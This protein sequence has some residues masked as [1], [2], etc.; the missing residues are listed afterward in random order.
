M[1]KKKKKSLRNDTRGY[2]TGSRTGRTSSNT[3]S[4]QKNILATK[5]EQVGK[6][7]SS[8]KVTTKAHR[9]LTALM[10]ELKQSMYSTRMCS[11]EIVKREEKGADDGNCEGEYGSAMIKLNATSVIGNISID[12]KKLVKKV[13]FLVSALL[14]LI[15]HWK[16]SFHA[17]Y[18]SL[19][20]V[21]A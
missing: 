15:A 17:F 14:K 6:S 13:G 18:V 9:E 16:Y 3:A 1:P 19:F 2:N 7:K 21:N 8:V 11:G 5:D 10:D 4:S 12:D 20:V